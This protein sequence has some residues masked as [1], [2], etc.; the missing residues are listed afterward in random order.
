M[1]TKYS[2]LTLE[3]RTII[4]TLVKGG[5][6][7]REIAKELC[8]APSTISREIRRNFP[9][10]L[11]SDHLAKTAHERAEKRK[12]TLHKRPRLKNNF[13]R[14]YVDEKIRLGWSPEQIA[15][16]LQLEHPELT[17]NHESIYRYLYSEARHLLAYLSRRRKRR[18]RRTFT[19][20]G[21][22]RRIPE[23]TP[24]TL[25]PPEIKDRNEVGH[26]EADTAYSSSPTGA[27][28]LV[29]TERK[30]RYLKVSKLKQ[31]TATD[32]RRALIRRFRVL[33]PNLRKTLTLDNGTENAQHRSVHRSLGMQTYFCRPYASYEKGTVENSIGLIRRIF[34]KGTSFDN[35]SF[36]QL[37]TLE[38]LLNHR[39]RKCLNFLTPHEAF[40]NECCT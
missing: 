17:T 10:D 39:P 33:P 25:R 40:I 28:L 1:G 2:Q 23:A 8:R 15:G 30:C 7:V 19:Q 11:Q 14:S 4:G 27:V 20:K 34:P 3:D 5:L 31:R 24:I 18:Q 13:I 35:V 36:Q 26:W 37:R 22:G 6:S 38:Q 9:K 29:M 32:A 21:R 12:C 16:R